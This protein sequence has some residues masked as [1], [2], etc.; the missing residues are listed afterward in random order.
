MESITALGVASNALEIVT[1][2]SKAIK[3][4]NELQSKY[5]RANLTF[6]LLENQL[7]TLKSALEEISEWDMKDCSPQLV[8]GSESATQS[9]S[10]LVTL[11]DEKL[12]SFQTDAVGDLTFHSKVMFLW[13]HAELKEYFGHLNSHIM[14]LSVLLYAH[15]R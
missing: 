9:I 10:I 6:T 15:S 11:L 4:I 12:Q 8:Q 3:N 2:L 13:D 7:I 14:S 5:R 1:V